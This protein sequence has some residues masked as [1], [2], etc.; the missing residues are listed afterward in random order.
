MG[1]DMIIKQI[2][3]IIIFTFIFPCF[4][5]AA[6]EPCTQEY[7]FSPPPRELLKIVTIPESDILN[8]DNTARTYN[9]THTKFIIDQAG[10]AN[11]ILIYAGYE[12]GLKLQIIGYEHRPLFANW[13]NEKLIY[14]EVW[15]NPHYGA[16][17]IYDVE[18]KKI[19]INEL[20]NDGLPAYQ[21]CQEYHKNKK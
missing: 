1:A 18:N 9:N 3:A 12:V 19:V 5:Y 20:Q 21:Q 17:W 7:L 16:Y 10:I 2:A 11:E 14:L 15:F 13:I 8:I 4:V 6:E